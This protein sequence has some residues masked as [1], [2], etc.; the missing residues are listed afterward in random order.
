M[1]RRASGR[2]TG[3]SGP[4][5]EL[6]QGRGPVFARKKAIIGPRFYLSRR[7]GRAAQR[8]RFSRNYHGAGSSS[9]S[10][11]ASAS[12]RASS[13]AG[14]TPS[15]TSRPACRTSQCHSAPIPQPR[16][17][18]GAKGRAFDSEATGFALCEPTGFH[19]FSTRRSVP[20]WT[21]NRAAISARDLPASSIEAASRR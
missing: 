10:A 21:P 8:R 20:T 15:A 11:T 18:T 6:D 2:G 4:N 12:R 14:A 9:R 5:K 3:F 19:A 1:A 13:A 7:A 16:E 17:I